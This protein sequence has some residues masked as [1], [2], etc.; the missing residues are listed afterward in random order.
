MEINNKYISTEAFQNFSSVCLQED[1][2]FWKASV[3]IYLF[4]PIWNF[5]I[6]IYIYKYIYLYKIWHV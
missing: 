5:Y 4:I 2:K 3:L 6:Y 1:E